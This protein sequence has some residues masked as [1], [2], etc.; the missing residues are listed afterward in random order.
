[1][2]SYFEFE[3]NPETGELTAQEAEF[4]TGEMEW[5]S[6]Y[7]RRG[8]GPARMPPRQV[9]QPRTIRKTRP[10]Q[11]PPWTRLGWPVRPRLTPAF[12]VIPWGGWVPTD[13]PPAAPSD[14]PPDEPPIDPATDAPVRG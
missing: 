7:A 6:E 12:P 1:M 2:T 4:G 11:H 9:R 8:R 10:P 3:T 14:V 5:E 13:V